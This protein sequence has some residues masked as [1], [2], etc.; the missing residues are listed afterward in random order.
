VSGDVGAGGDPGPGPGD[1][2]RGSR[3][4]ALAGQA[5]TL[6]TRAIL[7][8]AGYW[9]LALVQTLLH[10]R[11]ITEPA[12]GL[13]ALVEH[14]ALAVSGVWAAAAALLPMFVRGRHVI[15]DLLGA[16]GWATALALGTH[17]VAR[18][19][20]A[21]DPRGLIGAGALAALLALLAGAL[22]RT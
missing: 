9:W 7:G 13:R 14:P 12:A 5:S 21:G 20:G 18:A 4:P 2:A 3:D 10:E 22:R 16:V 1:Q 8:A 17:T 11:L 6:W 15:A 19:T